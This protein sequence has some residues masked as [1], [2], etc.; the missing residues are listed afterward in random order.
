MTAVAAAM[1]TAEASHEV[2]GKNPHTQMAALEALMAQTPDKLSALLTGGRAAAAADRALEAVA[3][4]D[5]TP[6]NVM[7]SVAKLAAK[8][9]Q[10]STGA[11]R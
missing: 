5:R 4:D 9:H 7:A 11:S 3:N 2:G 8:N 1:A 10:P 6:D